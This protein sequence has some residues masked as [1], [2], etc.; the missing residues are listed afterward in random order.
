MKNSEILP[1][2]VKKK[3]PTIQTLKRLF[4]GRQT[5]TD[6]RTDGPTLNKQTHGRPSDRLFFQIKCWMQNKK[7]P[8]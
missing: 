6:R 2:A 8:I 7:K 3:P 4:F 5:Q 1:T